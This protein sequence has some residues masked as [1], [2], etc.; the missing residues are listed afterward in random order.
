MIKA[1]TE[2]HV[3]LTTDDERTAS[4]AEKIHNMGTWLNEGLITKEAYVHIHDILRHNLDTE[5]F[6]SV[7]GYRDEREEKNKYIIRVIEFP[8]KSDG[9]IRKRKNID[10][11]YFLLS[12]EESVFEA[13]EKIT[14]E[15][16]EK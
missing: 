5:N 11:E 7:V 12:F 13:I 6:L 16:G 3:T 4:L 2:H 1:T 15:K 10:G 8:E 14:E 9:T